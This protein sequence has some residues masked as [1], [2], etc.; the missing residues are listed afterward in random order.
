MNAARVGADV[1]RRYDGLRPCSR[2]GVSLRTGGNSSPTPTCWDCRSVDPGWV[3]N[4]RPDLA[5]HFDTK[6]PA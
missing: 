4:R 2:C 3:R 1:I 5:A 6:V